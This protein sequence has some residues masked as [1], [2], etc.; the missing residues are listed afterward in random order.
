MDFFTW[1][2][3]TWQTGL[4]IVAIV[5]SITLMGIIE[6]FRPGGAPKHGILGLDTTRGDRLFISIIGFLWINLLWLALVSA[7]LLGAVVVGAIWVALV[8]RFV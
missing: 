1:M 7:P 4:F 3:W 2:A 8:F 6:I 5:G